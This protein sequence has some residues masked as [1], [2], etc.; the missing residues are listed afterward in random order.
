MQTYVDIGEIKYNTYKDLP[1][2]SSRVVNVVANSIKEDI[3]RKLYIKGKQI[4]TR[5]EGQ[6]H[7]KKCFNCQAYGHIS[8]DCPEAPPK[9]WSSPRTRPTRT[10][11]EGNESLSTRDSQD[12]QENTIV[13]SGE[14]GIETYQDNETMDV[15]QISTSDSTPIKENLNESKSSS[16]ASNDYEIIITQ[17]LEVKFEKNQRKTKRQKNTKPI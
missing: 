12:S 6:P 11:A 2:I 3:P 16:N 7:G 14:I 15:T 1:D 17:A 9:A 13:T 10:R 4:S 8:V 5:Y